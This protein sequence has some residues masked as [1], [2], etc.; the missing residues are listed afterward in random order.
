MFFVTEGSE[1]H[2]CEVANAVGVLIEFKVDWRHTK[3]CT[4]VAKVE[5]KHK[6]AGK[7]A[8]LIPRLRT[9]TC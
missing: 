7:W 5:L 2:P 4:Y 8:D 3:Y 1:P 9:A 6:A